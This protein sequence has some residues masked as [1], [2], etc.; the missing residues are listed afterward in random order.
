MSSP[1][2]F[3]LRYRTLLWVFFQLEELC[4]APSDTSIRE[5]LRKFPEGLAATYGRILGRLGKAKNK[6]PSKVFKWVAYAQRPLQLGELQEV[7]SREITEK[8]WHDAAETDGDR[9]IRSCRALVRMDAEDGTVRFAHHTVL[10]YLLSDPKHDTLPDFH[11]SLAQ[12]KG[13]G[14]ARP[15]TDG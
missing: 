10:Q 4:D 14:T 3:L 1:L 15:S 9:L 13:H 6:I 2:D 5:I 11:F 8:S 7:V 12:A